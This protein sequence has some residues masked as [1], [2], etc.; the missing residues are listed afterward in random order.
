MKIILFANTDWYLWNFRR[1]LIES[2][3]RHGWEVVL[4]SPPGPY[5]PE[6]VA[7]SVR[8][9][10]VDMHRKSVNPF[11]QL[12]TLASLYSIYRRERPDIVHHFTLKSVILGSLAAKFTGIDVCVHA[13]AGMGFIFSSQSRR[14]R[15]LRPFVGLLLK[16]ALSGSYSRV[17]FQNPDD[18][19][20]FTEAK[21]IDACRSRLIRGSGVDTSRFRPGLR[22]PSRRCRV[23]LATRL[24]WSKGIG[25]YVVAAGTL[26][27]A[28]VPADFLVAGT[29]DPGSPDS[30]P[31]ETIEIW[32]NEGHVCFLGHVRDMDRL[33]SDVD[34]VVLPSSYAEGVPRILLEAAACGAAIITTDRPGCREI[35][36]NNITGILLQPHDPSALAS[37]LKSLITDPVRRTK[38]GLA[39]RRK[40]QQ[41]FEESSVIQATIDVYEDAFMA[42]SSA[43]AG[44]KPLLTIR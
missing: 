1:E 34:I 12:K 16:A 23:L 33:L 31:V 9:I 38:L 3:R 4:I 21:V 19:K 30:V 22:V 41:E 42:R 24:L 18:L 2:I 10:S 29:P 40:A 5:G 15:I 20:V 8:W 17:I 28:G 35:V 32:Q 27:R 13:V 26:A 36:V 11:R 39:A 14:A 25:D 44:S 37:A 6:F 7:R 43:N